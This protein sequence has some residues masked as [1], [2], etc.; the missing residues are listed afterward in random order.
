MRFFFQL[1]SVSETAVN[2][3]TVKGMWLLCVNSLGVTQRICH[4]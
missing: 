4:S 2:E 3:A 1:C